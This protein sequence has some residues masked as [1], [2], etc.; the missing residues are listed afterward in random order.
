MIESWFGLVVV[1]ELAKEFE[2]LAQGIRIW[3]A[4]AD[5]DEGRRGDGLMEA[6]REELNGLRREDSRAQVGSA[7]HPL[8]SRAWFARETDVIPPKGSNS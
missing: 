2:L 6:E 1:R 8:R 3:V 5:R 7:K 4:Q